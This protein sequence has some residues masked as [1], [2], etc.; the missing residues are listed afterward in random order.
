MA[1]PPGRRHQ[2]Q[3]PSGSDPGARCHLLLIAAPGT[4]PVRALT[5]AVQ[6]RE[7]GNAAD[8]AAVLDRAPR[9]SELCHAVGSHDGSPPRGRRSSSPDKSMAG[10][11][12]ANSRLAF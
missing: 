4:D 3:P 1:P 6:A 5:D 8:P 7:L 9:L 11:T 10:G 12:L 2:R